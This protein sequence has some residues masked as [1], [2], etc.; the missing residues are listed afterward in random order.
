[1]HGTLVRLLGR[2]TAPASAPV[3]VEITDE[4]LMLRAGQGDRAAFE[5]LYLRYRDPVWGFFR[6]RVA[7]RASAEELSQETFLA[8]L[9]G[10]ARFEGR[11]AFRAYLFGIAFNILMAWRR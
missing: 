5:T 11:G 4:A 8:V 7:D 2:Q 6:R 9:T 3:V 1:M 10:A